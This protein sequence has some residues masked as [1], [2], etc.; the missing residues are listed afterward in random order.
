MDKEAFQKYLKDN[1]PHIGRSTLDRLYDNGFNSLESL[2]HATVDDLQA[3]GISTSRAVEIVIFFRARNRLF[4][5][6]NPI[7]ALPTDRGFI[8]TPLGSAFFSVILILLGYSYLI[9]S[10]V[11]LI[12]L[13][14]IFLTGLYWITVLINK[15]R[16]EKLMDLLT[17][18]LLAK[19]SIDIVM[20]RISVVISYDLQILSTAT[21]MMVVLTGAFYFYFKYKSRIIR[22]INSVL[23]F[24][25]SVLLM[26]FLWILE[27]ISFLISSMRDEM[28]VELVGILA[29]L[30]GIFSSLYFIKVSF[31]IIRGRLPD[32]YTTYILYFLL[33]TWGILTLTDFYRLGYFGISL[34]HQIAS[35]FLLVLAPSLCLWVYILYPEKYIPQITFLFYASLLIFN[36]GQLGSSVIR[37][38]FCI[39]GVWQWIG[40]AA[41]L[42]SIISFFLYSGSMVMGF[43]K[44]FRSD[45]TDVSI[46][47]SEMRLACEELLAWNDTYA[48][49]RFGDYLKVSD[50]TFQY[51]FY[52]IGIGYLKQALQLRS[53]PDYAEGS[54]KYN[55]ACGYSLS[56]D[57]TTSKRYAKEAIDLYPKLEGVLQRDEMMKNIAIEMK[58][59]NE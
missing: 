48:K 19:L 36:I 27:L 41:D 18:L 3:I 50:L 4:R 53:W 21:N 7:V 29:V 20:R 45:T 9:S 42:L 26:S 10:V 38:F 56:G 11:F 23:I 31:D 52:E 44:W 34:A 58:V 8:I 17:L 40:R 12:N 24:A 15:R 33:F 14:I 25:V 22:R 43:I 49:D 37:T 46:M 2:D 59:V 55:L 16:T 13:G 32:P 57:K 47:E 39:Q 35:G 5:F 28:S 54:L 51:G 1:I 30:L 6:A